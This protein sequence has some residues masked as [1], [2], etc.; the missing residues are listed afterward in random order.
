LAAPAGGGPQGVRGER[1]MG[2]HMRF[3]AR[4]DRRKPNRGGIAALPRKLNV[5]PAMLAACNPGATAMA[6]SPPALVTWP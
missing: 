4:L 3:L 1:C 2:R 5:H 6:M